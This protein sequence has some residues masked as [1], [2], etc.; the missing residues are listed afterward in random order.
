[1]WLVEGSIEVPVLD[2]RLPLPDG[3]L[4]RYVRTWRA[5]CRRRS[6]LL[7][8]AARQANAHESES[9]Q[10]PERDEAATTAP[11]S[12][13]RKGAQGIGRVRERARLKNVV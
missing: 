1:M 13:F 4:G 6:R 12:R 9:E 2:H 10:R 11:A 7:V 3:H 5:R 8:E